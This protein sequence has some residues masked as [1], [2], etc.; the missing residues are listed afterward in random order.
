[1]AEIKKQFSIVME[2]TVR[3][4]NG[5]SCIDLESDAPA[6]KQIISSQSYGQPIYDIENIKSSVRLYV[7]RAV[8]RLR[9]DMSLCKMIGVF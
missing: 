2:K 5:I 6:K 1:P 4:L 3:E 7:Q 8:S 9:D